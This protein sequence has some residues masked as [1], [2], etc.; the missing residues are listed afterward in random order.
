MWTAN[1]VAPEHDV[2]TIFIKGAS[3]CD[4]WWFQ[5]QLFEQQLTGPVV[6]IIPMVLWSLKLEEPF[7]NPWKNSWLLY[8]TVN[9]S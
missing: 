8:V 6:Q 9:H 7:W 2:D 1:Q 3:H 5:D 4:A